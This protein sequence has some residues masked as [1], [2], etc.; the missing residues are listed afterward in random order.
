MKEV[1]IELQ[2]R[3]NEYPVSDE[4][5]VALAKYLL[6]TPSFEEYWKEIEIDGCSPAKT[7]RTNIN[8][9]NHLNDL[10]LG[11]RQDMVDLT[12]FE[13]RLQDFLNIE[14]MGRMLD[15]TENT[16]RLWILPYL[17]DITDGGFTE[18]GIVQSGDLL[19]KALEFSNLLREREP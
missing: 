14:K 3:P 1:L 4:E 19:K 9:L 6:K 7:F 8:H 2:P 10:A 12:N 11:V 18:N 5:R 16:I 17:N 15:P 13:S